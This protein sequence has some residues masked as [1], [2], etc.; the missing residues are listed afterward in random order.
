VQE[1]VCNFGLL[2]ELFSDGTGRKYKCIVPK[3]R[4][5]TISIPSLSSSPKCTINT[6]YLEVSE[7][8]NERVRLSSEDRVSV[9]HSTE[10]VH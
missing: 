10:E 6:A 1:S 9:A 4:P 8:S 7:T 5:V 3:G 2:I